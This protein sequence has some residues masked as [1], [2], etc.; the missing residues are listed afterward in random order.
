MQLVPIG[1]AFT[2]DTTLHSWWCSSAW[3]PRRALWRLP[4]HYVEDHLFGWR[5]FGTSLTGTFHGEYTIMTRHHFGYWNWMKVWECGVPCITWV[6]YLVQYLYYLLWCYQTLIV[7]RLKRMTSLII[8]MYI[9]YLFIEIRKSELCLRNIYSCCLLIIIT[10][11]LF[12]NNLLL[13][14][15]SVHT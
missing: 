8:T 11:Y 2:L 5:T 9:F 6:I 3:W 12:N 13:L 7:I 10:A 1:M 4:N 14:V 15:H